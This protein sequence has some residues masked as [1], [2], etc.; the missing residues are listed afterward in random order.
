MPARELQSSSLGFFPTQ[1]ERSPPELIASTF[2]LFPFSLRFPRVPVDAETFGLFQSSS[3]T[4]SIWSI[5]RTEYLFSVTSNDLDMG[6]VVNLST[7][8]LENPFQPL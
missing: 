2:G 4:S 7:V 6:Q 8:H 3:S 5:G 1:P